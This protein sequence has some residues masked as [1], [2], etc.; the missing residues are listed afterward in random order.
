MKD[1]A[2]HLGKFLADGID[3]T[4]DAGLPMDFTAKGLASVIKIGLGD[5]ESKLKVNHTK[6]LTALK[7]N[8]EFTK[9]AG[10]TRKFNTKEY[11]EEFFRQG[12]DAQTVAKQAIK[13]A[14]KI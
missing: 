9:Y 6:L 7:Q 1:L 11:L 4:H 10:A 12:L 2:E 13:E 8:F 3:R 5:Y 14:E